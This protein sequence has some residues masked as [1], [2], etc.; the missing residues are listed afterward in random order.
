MILNFGYNFNTYSDDFQEKYDRFV[1]KHLD[2]FIC[3]NPD[4]SHEDNLVLSTSYFRDVLL[5][6]ACF[7]SLK[8]L[9]VYC[10]TCHHYHAILPASLIPY[11]SYAY[12]FVI[13][14]LYSFFFGQT[15][16]NKT[17]TCNSLNIDR[18]VLNHFLSIYSRE[19]VRSSH[20]NLINSKLDNLLLLLHKK[21]L[22]LFEFL[23]SFMMPENKILFLFMYTNQSFHSIGTSLPLIFE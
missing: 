21:R 15:K 9:V 22:D 2:S 11:C 17:K 12:I 16:G 13:K 10:P 14:I 23:L 18:K 20:L 5:D 8:T 19:E 7:F 3:P 1:R 6:V 4:C